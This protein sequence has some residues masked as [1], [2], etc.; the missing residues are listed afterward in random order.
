MTD[1]KK[2]AEL[3]SIPDPQRILQSLENLEAAFERLK[4]AVPAPPV[5]AI[6]FT[7]EP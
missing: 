7:P 2:A 1:W 4:A 3:A 5:M 6:R